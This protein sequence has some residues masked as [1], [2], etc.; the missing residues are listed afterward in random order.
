MR[1]ARWLILVPLVVVG[2]G[3]G[4]DDAAAPGPPRVVE[5]IMRDNDF[6][7]ASVLIE[8][9]ETITFR[10]T[11]VGAVEH[12]AFIGDEAAQTDHAG[13]HDHGGATA[14]TVAPGATGEL[15]YTFDE[16]GT[17]LMGCHIPGHYESGMVS[18]LVVD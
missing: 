6:D 4:D 7:K 2:C 11:N 3:G 15:T 9:G 16:K 14:V 12:E 13:D 8:R 1:T 17:L 5:M 18:R 10:F